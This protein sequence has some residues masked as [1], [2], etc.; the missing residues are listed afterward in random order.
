MINAGI[1]EL[2]RGRD[3]LYILEFMYDDARVVAGRR[4][5][6]HVGRE[7]KR[8]CHNYIYNMN[9]SRYGYPLW[10]ENAERALKTGHGEDY[11]VL[12]EFLKSIRTERGAINVYEAVSWSFVISLSAET[13]RHSGKPVKFPGFIRDHGVVGV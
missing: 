10:R 6:M 2:R 7:V 4:I 8:G 12:S 11:I 1:A 5:D 13:E 9:A 3:F